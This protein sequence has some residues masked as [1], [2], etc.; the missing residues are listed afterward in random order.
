MELTIDIPE[1]YTKED[2]TDEDKAIY[3]YYKKIIDNMKASA[4]TQHKKCFAIE[5]GLEIVLWE[6]SEEDFQEGLLNGNTE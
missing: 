1:R 2:A 3:A 4:F 6:E 5:N